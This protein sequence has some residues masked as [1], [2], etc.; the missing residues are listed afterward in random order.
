MHI[1]TILL[2]MRYYSSFGIHIRKSS[3]L[4]HSSNKLFYVR[5]KLVFTYLMFYEN[6]P[7]DWHAGETVHATHS[8]HDLAKD[9]SKDDDNLT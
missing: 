3:H 7:V 5:K 2:L 1:G 9:T 6:P 4:S 8:Y